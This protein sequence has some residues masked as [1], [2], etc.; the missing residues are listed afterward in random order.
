MPQKKIH[1]YTEEHLKIVDCDLIFIGLRAGSAKHITVGKL[2]QY[3]K[4]ILEQKK[5][6]EDVASS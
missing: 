5:K 2:T 6:V 4:Y 3:V 1:D